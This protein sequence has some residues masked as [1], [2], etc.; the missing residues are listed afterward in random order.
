MSYIGTLQGLSVAV[1]SSTASVVQARAP[2]STGL[3]VCALGEDRDQA[4]ASPRAAISTLVVRL[5]LKSVYSQNFGSTIFLIM[6]GLLIKFPEAK[7]SP[8]VKGPLL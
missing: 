4:L 3:G 6:L 1:P 8:Y 7:Y 5:Y 2:V